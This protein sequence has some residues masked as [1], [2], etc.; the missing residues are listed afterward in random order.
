M[1]HRRLPD[2]LCVTALVAAAA[3]VLGWLLLGPDGNGGQRMALPDADSTVETLADA[4]DVRSVEQAAA[5]PNEAWRPWQEPGFVSEG[6]DLPAW[7]RI[8][9]RN[10]AA[11]PARGMLTDALPYADRV[12]F[13]VRENGRWTHLESGEAAPVERQP[14]SGRQVAFPV[15][16]PAGGEVTVYL[17][18]ADFF[19]I[20]LEPL[21]W[22][23]ATAFYAWQSRKL[24]GEGCYF[25]VLLA[26]L[27]YNAAVWIR[28]RFPD[29]GRYLLYLLAFSAFMFF[30]RSGA[31]ELGWRMPSPWMEA[32]P[33]ALLA[34]SGAFL[35][36]FAR[37]FLELPGRL[38]RADRLARVVRATMALIALG[39]FVSPL[40]GM[41]AGLKFVS[42]GNLVTHV[43][44]LGV[45][46]A[47]WR[48]GTPQARYL[49]LAFGFLFAGVL[50]VIGLWAGILSVDTVTRLV[51]IGSGLEMLML[52]VATAGRFA[53]IQ[54]QHIAAKEALL[55]EG[56]QR[57]ALQEAY[58]DEL[59]LEVREQTRDLEAANADKDRM[60]MILGHDLRSP[61]AGLT[62]TAESLAAVPSAARTERFVTDAARTGREM[63]LLIEDLVLW[64]RLRAGLTDRQPAICS[65]WSVLAPAVALHRAQAEQT[66]IA[67][68]IDAAENL[69]VSTDLVL[70]Q[71]LVRNLVANALKF[72]SRRV[73]IAAT[74]TP[75]GI[76]LSVSNDG[77]ALPPGFT[78]PATSGTAG[79]PGGGL[80]LRLCAEIGRATGIELHVGWPPGG[81]AEFSFI[82][83]TAATESVCA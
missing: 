34:L 62:Q 13:Y 40:V 83:A 50:P 82:L 10:R 11:T 19:A 70:A 22:P 80:G 17:R 26:L 46:V 9:L 64:A 27:F 36:E 75:A 28:V 67:L 48:A 61:L 21:W 30:A 14:V 77:P 15:T 3:V 79:L 7:V 51:L 12:D 60:L 55:E 74:P 76:R 53:D 68:D 45:A 42:I 16:V 65:A 63:L 37:V 58:A 39:A 69:H 24:L 33:L 29:T 49:L 31:Q 72:A 1:K 23:D 54:R 57:Q 71:T 78:V 35:A 41:T 32:V 43:I 20:W 38:P 5:L 2:A 59:E 66:G 81:G 6:S 18:I 25:G 56:L 52:S 47:A 73:R 44:L 4:R 8:T